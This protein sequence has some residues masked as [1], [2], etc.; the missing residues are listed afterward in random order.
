MAADAGCCQ[1]AEKAQQYLGTQKKGCPPQSGGDSPCGTT[2]VIS[3]F[4]SEFN[5]FWVQLALPLPE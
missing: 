3:H 4:A 5:E 2:T 1:G